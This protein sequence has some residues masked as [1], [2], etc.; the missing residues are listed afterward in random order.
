MELSKKKQRLESKLREMESVVVA[1]SGG[2]D[3]A[4]LATVAYYVLTDKAIAVTAQ[5]NSLPQ[6]ELENA[7]NLAKEIGFK[8]RII[9]TG[10][11]N[12]PLYMSNPTDRCFH[13]KT[14]LY[15]SLRTVA[16]ELNFKHI[17]NGVNRDDLKDFRPGIS[18][19]QNA[20]V[21]TPLCDAGLDKADTRALAREL[22]LPVADKPASPCL[23]S[24]V[25][26]G[27]KITPEKLSMI[28][29]AEDFLMGLGFTQ[30][31]VRHYG[32]LARIELLPEEL[33]RFFSEGTAQTTEKKLHELGFS[34]V[35]IDP[36]GYRSGSL[37]EAIGK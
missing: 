29:L 19:G 12:N 36:R 4:L 20:G 32:S 3:S 2:V 25:P 5:S 16:N 21:L 7:K 28:E 8:H 1:Y 31:R 24:R 22:R 27:Q 30:L 6:R 34:C 13:C 9:M 26:Y 15:G 35:E 33:P 37:N 11:M 17:A 18:A 14:E 23:S 10:E